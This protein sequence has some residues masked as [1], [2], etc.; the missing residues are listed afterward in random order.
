MK[1]KKEMLTH[2]M[3]GSQVMVSTDK[4]GV[5]GIITR[6]KNMTLPTK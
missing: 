1:L 3:D 4:E 6:Q 5:A 2:K